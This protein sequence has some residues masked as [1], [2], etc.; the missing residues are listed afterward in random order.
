M[1][2]HLRAKFPSRIIELPLVKQNHPPA[3]VSSFCL[4]IKFQRSRK[5]VEGGGVL[6]LVGISSSQQHGNLSHVRVLLPHA[7]ESLQS[8]RRLTRRDDGNSTAVDE[9]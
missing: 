7:P 4:G 3:K 5:L 8:S 2:L 6:I 9:S 1:R